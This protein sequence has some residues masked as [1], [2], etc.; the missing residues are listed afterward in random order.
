MKIV[1]TFGMAFLLLAH[2]CSGSRTEELLKNGNNINVIRHQLG[3]PLV[4]VR[5]LPNGNTLWTFSSSGSFNM[6]IEEEQS[7]TVY[8]GGRSFNYSG[9]TTSHQ[10]IEL[11]CVIQIETIKDGWLLNWQWQG[12]NCP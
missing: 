12:N 6:P 3:A 2:A 4:D 8:S 5:E 10:R 1:P 7:G 11:H 9:T